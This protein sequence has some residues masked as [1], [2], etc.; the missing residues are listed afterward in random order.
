VLEQAYRR[1]LDNMVGGEAIRRLW[2]K[3]L[4]LWP[5]KEQKT[6]SL[7]SNLT[8]LDLPEKMGPYMSRVAEFADAVEADGFEDAVFVGLG[9]SNLGRKR[10][11]ISPYPNAGNG[12]LCWTAPIRERCERWSGS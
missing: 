12:F 5:A 4:S 1:E 9:D 2:A 6:T 3:D 10:S 8:W 7:N 11:R